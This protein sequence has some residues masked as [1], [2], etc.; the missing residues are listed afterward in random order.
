M[1]AIFAGMRQRSIE[2]DLSKS[3]NKVVLLIGDNGSGKSSILKEMHPFPDAGDSRRNAVLKGEDG[4]KEI[5][6]QKGKS[7][8]KIKHFYRDKDNS[9]KS[10]I[11]KNGK[12]LNP[13]GNK[14]SFM[15]MVLTEL[16]IEPSHLDILKLGSREISFIDKKATERKNYAAD[17]LKDLEIYS[18]LFKKVNDDVRILKSLLKSVGEK[19]EK[20]RVYSESQ[21]N[22]KLQ[23]LLE[24]LSKLQEQK[25]TLTTQKGSIEG[26]IQALIPQGV[27]QFVIEIQT[28]K[29]TQSELQQEIRQLGLKMNQLSI[30]VLSDIDITISERRENINKHRNQIAVNQGM[31][32]FYFNQL[33]QMYVLK[34]EKSN[35]LKYIS[36]DTEYSQISSLYTRLKQ[37]KLEL[38]T[39]FEGFTPTCTRNDLMTSLVILQEMDK[40]IT[41][42][43]EYDPKVVRK[44]ATMLLEQESIS[45]YVREEVTKI[46]HRATEIQNK[47]QMR[48]Q[49]SIIDPT[50]MYVL[51]KPR[52]CE[53]S[54]P[55]E[56]FYQD[57][58]SE[59][60]VEDIS[61]L[62]REL[63]SLEY[64]R[65]SLLAHLDVEKTIGYVLMAVKT[66]QQLIQRVP[67]ESFKVEHIY[68]I[69][70]DDK[71]LF[72]EDE[73]TNY[74]DVLEDYEKFKSLDDKI[75]EVKRELQFIE[76]QKNNGGAVN[77]QQELHD[78]EKEIVKY[79]K[80]ISN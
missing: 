37:E 53:C 41:S 31:L 8:Y 80:E 14:S 22:E 78:L 4:Y 75:H 28:N 26:T 56:K 64:Q 52:G 30:V 76:M 48:R 57:V 51:Y 38:A 70:R 5:H 6:Y 71:P 68:Q 67:I 10:F 45:S 2:I 73:I 13:N 79:E 9:V 69:I 34:E 60:K 46:D 7:I 44:V 43:R 47:I 66:N 58:M 42:I 65:E 35:N 12:E 61:S 33:E 1:A 72:N 17:L 11:E 18:K 32:E 77:T 24:H 15:E 49:N 25:D 21:E 39:R 54:C 74:I 19:I 62:E 3:K 40:I 23:R 63:V 50:A 36:S 20:L 16:G 29:R 55:F 59:Q 27:E